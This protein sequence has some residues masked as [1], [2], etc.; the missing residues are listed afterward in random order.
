MRILATEILSGKYPP[1]SKLP[2]EA[3]ILE[4]FSISRTLLRE[5]IK[6]LTAKGLVVPK[7]RVGTKVRDK[8]H[9]NF[10][11]ADVL[12]WRVSLGFDDGFR[13]DVS[14]IRLALEPKAA[15]LAAQR[16]TAEQI[17]YLRKCVQAMNEAIGSRRQFAEADLEFHQAVGLTSGNELIRSISG[18]IEAA[19]VASFML[20]PVE[21]QEMHDTTVAN[22]AKIVD[23]IEARNPEAA[24]KAMYD[25]INSGQERIEAARA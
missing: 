12:A 18:V 5:V 22:H 14:D 19:L 1:G 25:A 16:A 3:E 4:R 23:A 7:T 13:R 8:Q 24:A 15:A 2:Q 17:V 20:L 6:T 21:E 10:F 9:W 11:D